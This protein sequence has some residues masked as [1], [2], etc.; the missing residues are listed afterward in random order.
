MK[1]QQAAIHVKN[2]VKNYGSF[3]AVRGISFDVE[4]GEIF[5][6]VGPNGAGKSTTINTLC[7][8]QPK[9]SG[10]VQICGHDTQKEMEEVRKCI[11]VVF[12]D[13][14]LDAG[15]TVEETL[16]LHC[17]IYGVPKN[18]VQDRIDFV[19]EL[20]DL[21]EQRN[22]PT[23]ALSGGMKRRVE[24]ARAMLHFPKVLFLD[25]PT[26]G[27]D[28]KSRENVWNYIYDLQQKQGTT[29]FLTTH[30]MEEAEV[31]T[32]MAV[33]QAG[34]ITA[35]DTPT[36]LK[37]EYTG[38]YLDLSCMDEREVSDILLKEGVSAY[39]FGDRLR[40]KV[41]STGEAVFLLDRLKGKITDFEFR[42]GTLNDV[43]LTLTS[44]QDR[45]V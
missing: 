41:D 24:I 23:G 31:C 3:Q 15:M 40:A 45:S 10:E 14:T 21:S 16:W 8:I 36:H 29:I 12:Q 2:F 13:I 44:N 33:M 28:P 27:L 11:G 20:V 38:T 26:T 18:E 1:E 9:T 5:G 19:L 17:E 6:F 42:H 25:E 30:Y 34:R 35:M 22:K 43:F 4:P 7:T 37:Q 32:H 39:A